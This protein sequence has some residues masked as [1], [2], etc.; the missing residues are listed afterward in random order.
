MR[1]LVDIDDDGVRWPLARRIPCRA[2][3]DH[4]GEV[5]R[6]PI[7]VEVVPLVHRMIFGEVRKGCAGLLH[8]RQRHQ[9]GQGN[10]CVPTFRGAARALRQHHRVLGLGDQLRHPRDVFLCAHELRCRRHSAPLFRRRPGCHHRFVRDRQ[11]GRADRRALRH[12]ARPD[13][14]LID[15]VR[16]RR[17]AGVLDQRLD[18]ALRPADDRQV[19]GPLTAGIEIRLLPVGQGFTGDHQH[20]DAGNQST[21]HAHQALQKSRA[22]VQQNGLHLTGRERV[23]GGDVDRESL[24]PA[25]HEPRAVHALLDLLGHRLPY[26]GPFRARGG[27][28]V[29]HPEIANGLENGVAAVERV[30]HG[31]VSVSSLGFFLAAQA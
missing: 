6:A 30:F 31:A 21:V 5:R 8:D 26:R 22:G 2:R 9:I 4:D 1:D 19:V 17:L 3:L 24:V 16:A 13:D 11:V 7:L 28:D 14:A 25:I 29:L 12:L 27:K 20:R 23:A 18:Q 15:R 10:Q